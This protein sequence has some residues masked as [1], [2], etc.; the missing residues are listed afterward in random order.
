MSP[1]YAALKTEGLEIIQEFQH[2]NQLDASDTDG[3][4]SSSDEVPEKR[5]RLSL[6]IKNQKKSLVPPVYDIYSITIFILI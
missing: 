3:W 6:S 4:S 5:K 2:W 1:L